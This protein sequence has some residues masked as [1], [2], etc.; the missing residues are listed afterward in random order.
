MASNQ[1][2]TAAVN[3]FLTAYAQ[4]LANELLSTQ[5]VAEALCPTVN[6]TGAAGKFKKFSD[7]NSFSVYSTQRGLGG[8]AKRILFDATDGNFNC[9]PQAL[10]ATV[11]QH[12]RALAAAGGNPLAN[13][14]LDQGKVKA[15]INSTALS[16]VDKVVTAVNAA[17]SAQADVGNWSNNSIDP[18]DQLDL[19][20]DGLV[21]D[22]GSDRNI[23]LV[24]STTAWRAL[25]NHPKTKARCNG[26]QVGGISREQLQAMLF[27]PCNVVIGAVSKLTNK[28]GQTISGGSTASAGSKSNVIGANAYLTY[29]LPSPTVYDPSA[30]KCFTTGVG[31]VNSVRT[32]RD[33]SERFDVHAVDWSEDIQL[34]SSLCIR[35]FSIT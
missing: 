27:I 34:C 13:E 10:E 23:N 15:L 20:L 12:E 19:H 24:L 5:A 3:Y 22:V 11:D 33:P 14:L 35:R 1:Q 31:N 32:Y 25:R 21:T 18:V 30:F 4:G 2:T 28:E 17:V 8:V 6:V 16:H 29:S 9:E 26:V 7:R